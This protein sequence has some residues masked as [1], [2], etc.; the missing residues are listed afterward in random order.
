M[1]YCCFMAFSLSLAIQT[2]HDPIPPQ[3]LFVQQRLSNLDA[4]IG[5]QTYEQLALDLQPYSGSISQTSDTD[6]V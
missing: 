5:T 3:P 4:E 1:R 6:W 2:Y